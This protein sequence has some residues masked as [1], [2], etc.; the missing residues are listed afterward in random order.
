LNKIIYFETYYS[1][2]NFIIILAIENIQITLEGMDPSEVEAEL[3]IRFLSK[4]PGWK[5]SN[6]QV[7][8]I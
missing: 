7:Y 4:K 2:A 1:F 5:E 3:V 6:F 8:I